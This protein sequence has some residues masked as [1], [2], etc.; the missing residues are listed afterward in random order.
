L[1]VPAGLALAALHCSV[2]ER[3]LTPPS[4]VFFAGSSGEGGSAGAPEAGDAGADAG[5]APNDG[6]GAGTV[7]ILTGGFGGTEISPSGGAPV[8]GASPSG[9][10]SGGADVHCPDLDLNDVPDCLETL[11]ANPSFDRSSAGWISETG[12]MATWAST[13]ADG[14]KDSG[15]LDVTNA[16][17]NDAGGQT[18]GGA[19]QCI[20]VA[21]S[22]VYHFAVQTK[23]NAAAVGAQAGLQLLV[24]DGVECTGANIASVNSNMLSGVAWNVSELTY[25][26]PADAQ[27]IIV[28]LAVIKQLD[29][30]TVGAS[31]DNVLV[32]G[33]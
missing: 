8:A 32:R 28:R 22:T 27:S 10:T 16:A 30:P 33:Q 2:D 21:G 17:S 18:L 13:D 26:T 11:V 20:S 6:G 5:G 14:Q 23:L 3:A 25:V 7:F 19:R 31:F 4:V 12:L 29:G 9:G 1:A 15:S 24:N